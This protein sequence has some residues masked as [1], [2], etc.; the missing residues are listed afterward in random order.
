MWPSVAALA[1]ASTRPQVRLF[2]STLVCS[3]TSPPRTL[4]APL[5]FLSYL[6]TTYSHITS[7][8][9]QLEGGP[10]GVFNLSP[11]CLFLREL[12]KKR[13][14]VEQSKISLQPVRCSQSPKRT[15]IWDFVQILGGPVPRGREQRA[16]ARSNYRADK[17]AWAHG[18][19][20]WNC[21]KEKVQRT[22]SPMCRF[23]L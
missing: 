22:K 15:G 2:L 14:G 20:T 13:E 17:G 1:R 19:D 8:W 21:D 18:G 11:F 9:L 5:P 10:L 3:F 7:Q 4:I 12:V 16:K 23:M 6:F